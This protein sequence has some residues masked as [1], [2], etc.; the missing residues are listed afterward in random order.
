LRCCED[1]FKHCR[2]SFAACEFQEEKQRKYDDALEED[3]ESI[4]VRQS[5]WFA[6]RELKEVFEEAAK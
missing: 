6:M 5:H 4:R 3:A 1:V 2:D